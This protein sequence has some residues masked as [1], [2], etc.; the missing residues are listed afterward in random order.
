MEPLP[1]LEVQSRT[2]KS[3]VFT[4]H[5]TFNREERNRLEGSIHARLGGVLQ[6]LSRLRKDLEKCQKKE[7]GVAR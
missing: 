5:R 7:H 6:N 3:I 4:A 1:D 2:W